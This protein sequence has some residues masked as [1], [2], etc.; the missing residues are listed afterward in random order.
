MGKRKQP[1]GY[2]MDIGH[3]VIHPQEAEVVQYI[4]R[5]YISGASFSLI[6]NALNIGAVPYDQ[7]K[8]WNKNMVARI[9]ADYRYTGECGCPEIVS[10]E[11]MA[12][13]LRI[14]SCKQVPIQK[15]AA[16]K[17]IRQLSG[18]SATDAMEMQVLDLLNS[19]CGRPEQLHVQPIPTEGHSCAELRT[20]LENIMAVWP[21]DEEA[22]RDLILKLAAAQ[23]DMIGATEYETMRLKGIFAEAK[24]MK[25]LDAELL[26]NTVAE[27]NTNEN[28]AV[29]L[30]LKNH[31][32]VSR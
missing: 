22:A 8:P 7:G 11:D 25:S 3:I 17:A 19:L 2:C 21:V 27:I 15:T 1:F 16:Q 23:Y 14:R 24:P 10:Q 9:L 18:Q 32:I 28:G 6:T 26:K 4:F 31:Q 20:R 13:V 12:A 29:S 30:K 5:Q